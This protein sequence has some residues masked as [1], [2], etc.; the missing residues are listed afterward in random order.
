MEINL[1][2]VLFEEA[3]EKP[4]GGEAEAHIVIIRGNKDSDFALDDGEADFD[5][6]E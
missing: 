4:H 3:K 2:F 6:G 5:P 1:N